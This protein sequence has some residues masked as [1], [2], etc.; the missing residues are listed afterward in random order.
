LQADEDYAV[1]ILADA[2]L[3]DGTP[4]PAGSMQ[5]GYGIKSQREEKK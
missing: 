2:I 4:P 3:F 1:R 5:S